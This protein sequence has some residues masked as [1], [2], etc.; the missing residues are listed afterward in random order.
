MDEKYEGYSRGRK[1]SYYRMA[2]DL[3]SSAL[4]YA[5]YL[6]D[7]YRNPPGGNSSVRKATRRRLSSRLVGANIAGRRRGKYFKKFKNRHLKRIPWLVRRVKE[8]TPPPSVVRTLDSGWSATAANQVAYTTWTVGAGSD[9]DSIAQNGFTSAHVSG[10][11]AVTATPHTVTD[12]GTLKWLFTKIRKT[13]VIKVNNNTSVNMHLMWITPKRKVNK[14]PVTYCEDS[15]DHEGNTSS[16]FAT[17]PRYNFRMIGEFNKHFK[18][19]KDKK[20]HLEPGESTTISIQAPKQVFD[21]QR[22][23]EDAYI[24]R[25]GR[26]CFLVCR[27]HGDVAHDTTLDE[28]VGLAPCTFDYVEYHTHNYRPLGSGVM[29]KEII[30]GAFDTITAETVNPQAPNEMETVLLTE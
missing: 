7:R 3:G 21:P 10:A 16:T 27:F 2:Y 19:V 28:D 22:Y 29:H 15:L 14:P 9:L 12:Q 5:G 18:I 6:L 23:D 26:T 11:T 24:Y 30:S 8:L 25:P 20:I 17:D 1:R 13:I 4:P